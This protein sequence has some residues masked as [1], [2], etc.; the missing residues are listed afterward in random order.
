MRLHGEWNINFILHVYM[1]NTEAASG[2][3]PMLC[4]TFNILV[5]LLIWLIYLN[6]AKKNI[7]LDNLQNK[8]FVLLQY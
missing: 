4:V 7:R 1:L 8:M 2:S 6:C 5:L 3:S